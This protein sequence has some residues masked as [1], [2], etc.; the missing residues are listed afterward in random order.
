LDGALNEMT[1]FM[2]LMGSDSI[3]YRKKNG[4][5]LFVLTDGEKTKVMNHAM[6]IIGFPAQ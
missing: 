4:W 2:K 3:Q 5:N 6:I 1:A